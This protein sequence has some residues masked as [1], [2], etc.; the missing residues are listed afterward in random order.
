VE[1]GVDIL[2]FFPMASRLAGAI[3]GTH[4]LL[5]GARSA[6]RSAGAWLLSL[7]VGHRLNRV[8]RSRLLRR[9]GVRSILRAALAS[10]PGA[11]EAAA[12][13]AASN[14][15]C[16]EPLLAPRE[17]AASLQ[18]RAACP[19]GAESSFGWRPSQWRARA[20]PSTKRLSPKCT[21]AAALMLPVAL[22]T[23]RLKTLL[24]AAL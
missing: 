16:G 17:P 20:P 23:S 12:G 11:P 3:F 10:A 13:A 8:P 9:F 4:A 24:P 7:V 2:P 21:A 14:S 18:G 15:V 6:A 22:Q 1:T 19:H 5:S